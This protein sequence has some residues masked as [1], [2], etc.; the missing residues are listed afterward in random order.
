MNNNT[1]DT[2]K[3]Q[4]TT[5]KVFELTWFDKQGYIDKYKLARFI[6]MGSVAI[7]IVIVQLIMA[8]YAYT[9]FEYNLFKSQENFIQFEQTIVDWYISNMES[10]HSLSQEFIILNSGIF[11]L[12]LFISLKL[13]DYV[14]EKARM[15]SAL[16]SIGLNQFYVEKVDKNT[17]TYTF[18]LIK[19]EKLNYDYFKDKS[20]NL[21]QIFGYQNSIAKRL[22]TNRI[23][24]QFSENF[25]EIK[26]L[27]GLNVKNFQVKG[28][29]F[30]GIG[31]P[32]IGIKI[33]KKDLI[34]NKF[35]PKYIEFEDL[36]QGIGNYGSASFGKSNTLNMVFQGIFMNF[37]K[38]KSFTFIDFKQG[39]EA[40]P[41][42]LLEL[43]KKTGRIFT[44][45]D[46]RL[47]LLNYLEKL[48]IITKSRGLYIKDKGFKKIKGKAIITFFDE[49]AEVLDYEPKEKQ[50]KLI[51][52][53]IYQLIE[54]LL[55]I[56]RAA[57]IIIGYSTQSP[58]QHTSGLSSGMKN[59]TPLRITHGL[60]SSSQVSSVYEDLQELGY[61]PVDYDIGKLAVINTT[62]STIF[63]SRA[64]FVPDDFTKDIE[65]EANIEDEFDT[66][67]KEY[68]KQYVEQEKV[69]MEK[70]N[71]DLEDRL[72]SLDELLSDLLNDKL[73]NDN[74]YNNKMDEP[75][76]E[77]NATSA[78]PPKQEPKKSVKIDFKSKAS[79]YKKREIKHSTD[80]EV[81]DF[82]NLTE[83]ITQEDTNKLDKELEDTEF[84]KG[85][86]KT[87][88]ELDAY[89][90]ENLEVSEQE[91][92]DV[93]KLYNELN[94]DIPVEKSIKEKRIDIDF[95]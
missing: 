81:Q 71:I 1:T 6:F 48:E 94:L 16:S 4:K 42:R 44:M 5:D 90:I 72:F 12:L 68:Y 89:E 2:K 88:N 45:E 27:K 55:R 43:K 39:L 17:H 59:N 87:I 93:Q 61:N 50:E 82:L 3:A 78:E 7:Y 67:I 53:R 76:Y 70:M 26:D 95:I 46:D 73:V 57:G 66:E 86:D 19:G 15:Q 37:N 51:Q 58:L 28:K 36:P 20:G 83:N 62:N 13:T 79:D 23:I 35:I 14:K 84:Y 60:T 21:K 74:L 69:R 40:E 29:I 18:K 54:S 52:N 25:P 49:M 38:V 9:K 64:L 85:I 92:A 47:K 63:E 30:M 33:D 34:Q 65:F 32:E 22:G 11:F 56:G 24:V 77:K 80:K 75:L 41:Y 8:I 91:S 31:L 10:L